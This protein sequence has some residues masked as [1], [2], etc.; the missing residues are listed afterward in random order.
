MADEFTELLQNSLSEKKF[1]Q[2]DNAGV[3]FQA[4][5]EEKKDNKAEPP[6]EAKPEDKKTGVLS[7]TDSPKEEKKAEIKAEAKEEVKTPAFEDLLAERSEGKFK[8]W[9]EI[10]AKLSEPKIEFADE[11][12]RKINDYIRDGGKLDSDWVYFQNTD[13]EKIQDPFELLSEAMRL[14]EPGI[15]DKEI[16]Y[17]LK[18]DYKIDD[19][20][21]E[22]AEANEVE[23]VMSAKMAREADKARQKLIAHK[24]KSSFAVPQ[25]SEADLR[26]EAEASKVVQENWEKT[27]EDS[28]KAFEKIPV[29]IDDKE[30]FDVIVSDEEKKSLTKMT[31]AMGKSLAP[32][33]SE[34]TDKKGNVDVNMLQSFM[35]KAK[36]FD[37]AVKAAW[38]QALAKGKSEIVK[39]LKN[40]NF[41]KDGVPDVPKLK[42]IGEQI[43]EQVAKQLL[44]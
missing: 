22:G 11:R 19:W 8:S 18:N 30:T 40:V 34:F 5:I 29:K 28:A 25:K 27:V 42:S 26:K 39:D 2:I 35:Y 41:T 23:E 31:K 1:E 15:T 13:F 7:N 3:E 21:E 44:Q 12:V 14:E 6:Q 38:N 17:R 32:L 24:T 9:E 4:P 33:L 36:N 20:S 10:Q 37:N 16:E 43:G